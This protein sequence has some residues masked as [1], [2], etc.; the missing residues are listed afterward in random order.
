MNVIVPI[1]LAEITE[2]NHTQ[3]IMKYVNLEI[4]LICA[5]QRKHNLSI[6]STENQ[7]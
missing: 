1:A 7:L 5:Y 2:L 6:R 4:Y 3:E